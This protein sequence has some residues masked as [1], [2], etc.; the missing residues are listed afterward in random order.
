[1][2]AEKLLIR[3]QCPEMRRGWSGAWAFMR[4]KIISPT[5]AQASGRAFA[6]PEV[7]IC[8]VILV[9]VY[10]TTISAYIVTDRRAEWSG[11]SLAAQGL[12]IRQLE[13]ARAAKW[14]T[15]GSV[16]V[17]YSTNV[18]TTTWT[19][20]DIPYQGTNRI[21]ATNFTT[22]STINVSTNGALIQVHMYRVDTVWLWRNKLF[23]NSIAT[24]RGPN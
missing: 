1:M 13:E 12:S 2:M 22:I 16:P 3:L 5:A 7:L 8:L 21:Y 14:D 19:N 11:Y 24:Y 23:T 4:V 17:D 18:P 15:Q 20:L 10:G 9:L 6:L